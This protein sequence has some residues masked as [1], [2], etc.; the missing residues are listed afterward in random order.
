MEMEHQQNATSADPR[1]ES[2]IISRICHTF[3]LCVRA[4]ES[5]RASGGLLAVGLGVR[6]LHTTAA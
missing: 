4:G 5:S 6:K 2:C 1:P 3:R